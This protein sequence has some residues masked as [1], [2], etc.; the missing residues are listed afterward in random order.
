MK[1]SKTV[2]KTKNQKP[3]DKKTQDTLDRL[4]TY[5]MIGVWR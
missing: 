1:K 2:K 3:L 5:Y 4:V